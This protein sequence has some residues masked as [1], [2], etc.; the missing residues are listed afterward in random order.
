[1]CVCP[2]DEDDDDDDKKTAA[3]IMGFTSD[4]EYEEK[5]IAY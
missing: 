2:T 3:T 5:V 1:M 4:Q